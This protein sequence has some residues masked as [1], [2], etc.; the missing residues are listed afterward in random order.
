MR[1]TPGTAGASLTPAATT[2]T[3]TAV[4]P[5]GHFWVEGDNP[6]NSTDSA[7]RFGALPLGLLQGRVVSVVW[8]PSR[9][10]AWLGREAEEEDGTRL[11]RRRA[12]ADE[13]RT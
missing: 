7:S 9:F 6:S 13:A 10:R 4:V 3:T 1:A 8:P 12:A 5:A 2:T 11:V